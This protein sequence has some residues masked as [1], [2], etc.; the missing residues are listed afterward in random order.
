MLIITIV[1]IRIETSLTTKTDNVALVQYF[2]KKKSKAP[3]LSFIN[4]EFGVTAMFDDY[5]FLLKEYS[6]RGMI[7]ISIHYIYIRLTE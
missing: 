1:I 7:L 2:D 4:I 3:S 5:T 6:S